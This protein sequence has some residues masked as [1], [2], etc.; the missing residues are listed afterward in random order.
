MTKSAKYR[1][2]AQGFFQWVEDNV[3]FHV[4]PSPESTIKKWLPFSKLS[5]GYLKM[6]AEQKKVLTEALRMVRGRFVY[7]LIILMWPRGEGKS[8]LTCLIKIWRLLNFPNMVIILGANSINQIRFVHFEEITKIIQNS[9]K[10]LKIIGSKNVKQKEIQLV[11]RNGNVVSYIRPVSSFSG[12]F[13]NL[14]GY[15]FSEFHQAIT[16]KFFTEIDSS[17]RFV[18]NA[19]GVIDTTVASKRH[20]LYKIYKACKKKEIKDVFFSFRETTGKAEEFWNPEATQDY[21][22]SQKVTLPIHDYERFFINSWSAGSEKVFTE[23][24][25]EATN[26]IG[27]DKQLNTHNQ[28]IELLSEKNRLI[29]HERQLLAPRG[30]GKTTGGP[31]AEKEMVANEYMFEDMEKRLWPIEDIY[32]LRTE[33]NL[34]KMATI[35]DLDKLSDLYDTYWAIET[36][37]DR[38][39]PMKKRTAAR[40]IVV[41]IAKGLVGSRS[42]PYIAINDKTPRY[43]YLVIHLAD[44]EDH[45]KEEIESVLREIHDEFDGI[46]SFGAERWGTVDLN[47]W[48]EKN[49]VKADIYFP[50][51]DKQKTMFSE[52]YLAYYTGRFK[53][54]PLA[55]A[56]YKQNDILQEE[57]S[58]FDHI[59]ASVG[60]WKFGSPEKSEKYGVQ[61]DAMY[62]V[63]AAIYGG[64]MLGVDDFR[65][66]KAQK[67]FGHFF[68]AK[69][70]EGRY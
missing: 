17:M 5:S 43:L 27:V 31:L 48:C 53:V 29:E 58:V 63:G 38:A 7:R 35:S 64:R 2:G 12:I 18:K 24:M 56:G 25:I 45:S 26:Y 65:E 52:V 28:L 60:R 15:T 9:P 1:N 36:G 69:G 40:S 51:Y 16:D 19:L 67:S 54:A 11:D 22:D 66:R 44:V 50:N 62:A 20:I 6:W 57:A 21:L 8:A 61:D 41:A 68:A 42:N 39:D 33:Q 49:E 30:Q 70:L 13:S 47:K 23:E 3:C 59:E 14:T 10:L 46:D 34:P 4:Y 37:V 32:R 55:V